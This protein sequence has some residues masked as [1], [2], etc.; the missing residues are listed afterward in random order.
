MANLKPLG[1]HETYS[2]VIYGAV[3]KPVVER[4]QGVV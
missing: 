4:H 2:G 3:S 1:R